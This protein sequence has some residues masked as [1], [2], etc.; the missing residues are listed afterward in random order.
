MPWSSLAGAREVVLPRSGLAPDAPPRPFP[1]ACGATHAQTGC[2]ARLAAR[3][4]HEPP[5]PAR[6]LLQV[7]SDS[8]MLAPRHQGCSG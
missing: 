6:F 1:R 8:A 7:D 3:P 5:P 2:D 4:G